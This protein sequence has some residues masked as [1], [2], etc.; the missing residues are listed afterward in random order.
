[1]KGWLK[2]AADCTCGENFNSPDLG[3]KL[4]VILTNAGARRRIR[5]CGG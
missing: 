1:M 3:A 4:S 5:F 2:E